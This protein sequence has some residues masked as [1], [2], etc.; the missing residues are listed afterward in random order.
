MDI[1]GQPL[2]LAVKPKVARRNITVHRVEEPPN[3]QGYLVD[4]DAVPMIPTNDIKT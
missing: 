3:D 1:V 2:Q 4:F